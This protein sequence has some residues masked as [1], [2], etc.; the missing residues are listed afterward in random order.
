MRTA[1]SLEIDMALEFAQQWKAV[2][3]HHFIAS[4]ATAIM[5]KTFNVDR[6]FILQRLWVVETAC[7]CSVGRFSL[8]IF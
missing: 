7:S 2:R 4:S 6:R 5:D 3:Y 8:T 1:C